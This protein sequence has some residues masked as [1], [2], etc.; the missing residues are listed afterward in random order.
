MLHMFYKF[1][2]PIN[3]LRNLARVFRKNNN[4]CCTDFLR[5][6]GLF[7][8]IVQFWELFL[9]DQPILA[10]PPQTFPLMSFRFFFSGVSLALDLFSHTY[11]MCLL[12]FSP[13]LLLTKYLYYL[14]LFLSLSLFLLV[15]AVAARTHSVYLGTVCYLLFLLLLNKS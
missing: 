11:R 10:F 8:E 9:A 14:L 13:Y 1:I 2:V 3:P 15:V 7:A 12:V 4:N 5:S 6:F